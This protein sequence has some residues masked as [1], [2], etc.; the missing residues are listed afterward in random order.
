MNRLT[1]AFATILCAFLL[2][3]SSVSLAATP[4]P[5]TSIAAVHAL[6]NAEAAHQL[7]AAFEA[8]VTYY[9]KGD[10]DLF[11]Q[12]GDIAIYV[13]TSPGQSLALGARVLVRGTTN[14][15]FRPEIKS[16]SIT[17]LRHGVPPPPVPATFRQMIRAELDCRRV[18]VHAVVRS[19]NSI[20]DND[21]QSISLQL[22]MD[23]GNIDAEVLE[24]YQ[25]NLND[26]LDREVEL[27]GAV[28]GRFD[29]KMQMTGI[30]LEVHSLADLKII[31]RPRTLP[32]ALPVTPMDEILR[33]YDIQDR[34]RRVRVQ[35]VITYYQP[36]SALVLQDGSKSLWVMTQY[37]K[38]L[39]LGERVSAT[40]FADVRNHSLA[41]TRAQIEPDGPVTPITPVAASSTELASGTHSFDLVSVSGRLLMAVREA[42]Q[43]EYFV[44]S[45]GHLFSAVYRHPERGEDIELPPMTN[46]ALGSAVRMTGICILDSGARFEG[47]VAF[48][49]LLR[50]SHDIA[51]IGKPSP[52]TVR[53][54]GTIVV[55]LLVVVLGISARAWAAER[56]RRRQTAEAA[57]LEQRR[58]RIL[59]D[60]NGARPLPEIL[61]Q[62]TELVS[63]AL[64][65]APCWLRLS[66]DSQL[67]NCPASLADKR[68]IHNEITSRTK[69]PLGSIS[70][71]V[72]ALTRP[73]DDEA[74]LLS[75]AAELATLAIESSRLYADLVHRSE[76]DLLTD[77]HNRFS[78]EKRIDALI[79]ASAPESVPGPTQD[80]GTPAG[81]FG[82][83]YIDLD[84][85]KHVN[86]FYGHRTGDLYLQCVALRMKRQ[87]RPTDLLARLGGDEFAVVV[88]TAGS[89]D[90]LKD[91]AHRI[92]RSFDEP[93]MI[94]GV[95]LRGSASVGMAL[96]PDDG[97]SR[98][99]LL[100]AA[101]VAMYRA[102]RA[103]ISAQSAPDVA[104]EIKLFEQV[105]RESKNK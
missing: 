101:D 32:G 11:V 103:K 27:T 14:A 77:I 72:G 89:H 22:L 71:A 6:S 20:R 74:R 68:V 38:R 88:E 49:M 97:L 25:G 1:L 78:L 80:S 86:D 98:D 24:T 37:E 39:Q 58:S 69:S 83:I 34:S 23:G 47:P 79:Q 93:F 44:V 33:D 62:I 9:K 30:L 53:N 67:G 57:V 50:S 65:G 16:D 29:S 92:E 4:G 5:L 52:L 28:A 90:Y 17:V 66:D 15:S 43:D 21:I 7:P 3:G 51:V 96:F 82:L 91:I 63:F 99:D 55:L 104:R 85:F 41:L 73:H 40:G 87:V 13:L 2:E 105:S 8:T 42:A 94:D 60:I 64:G 56:R 18:T 76:F 46:I 75:V 59:E 100:S 95:P 70:V 12:D 31:G 26:L 54:L 19:A 81:S 35:G 84:G 48:E 102:K 61:L 45:D 36:G 10:V